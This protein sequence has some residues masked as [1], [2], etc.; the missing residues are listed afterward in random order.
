VVEMRL[1]IGPVLLAHAA[2]TDARGI[3]SYGEHVAVCRLAGLPQPGHYADASAASFTS[4]SHL[5][6]FNYEQAYPA[7]N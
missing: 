2:E 7:A 5:P 6:F 4:G 1:P 3:R